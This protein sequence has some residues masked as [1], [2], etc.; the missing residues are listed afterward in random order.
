M[1]IVDVEKEKRTFDDEDNGEKILVE[2]YLFL[3]IKSK[4]KQERKEG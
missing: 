2:R 3:K 4:K 1:I